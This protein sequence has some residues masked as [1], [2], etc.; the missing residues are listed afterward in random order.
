MAAQ[1]H[2]DEGPAPGLAEREEHRAVRLLVHDRV[3]GRVAPQSVAVETPRA[4]RL[5]QC[6]V[7][8]GAVVLGP[9]DA[10]GRIVDPLGE[11]LAGRQIL[12]EERVGLGTGRI[13]GVGQEPVIRT[14]R[15]R[16]QPEIV[17]PLGEEILVERDLLSGLERAMAAAEDRVLP[18]LLGSG[19]VVPPVDSLRHRQVGLLN[20]A[21]HLAIQALLESLGVPHHRGGIRVLCFEV[22][23]DGRILAV[24][25]PV[26]L[27]DP[28]IAVDREAVRPPV[29]H[30]GLTPG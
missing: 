6:R 28:G 21:D 11:Q 27:V 10:V 15:Q 26:V 30:R 14:Q 13:G 17:V 24:A 16:A 22:A 9:F 23:E 8:E 2:Q 1:V 3:G 12:H 5:V 25:K 7:E 18:T 20:S 4:S 19:V 29:G